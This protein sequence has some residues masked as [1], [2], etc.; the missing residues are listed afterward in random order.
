[1][2]GQY[3]FEWDEHNE[4]HI[5]DHGV[6]GWEAEEA[7]LDPNRIAATVYR[8]PENRWGALGATEA[9]RILFLVFTRRKGKI[10]VVTAR[11]AKVKEKRRYR[12]N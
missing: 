8:T 10:R 6:E 5:A 7:L 11:D 4:S 1:M 3:A 12:G 9:G 2:Q